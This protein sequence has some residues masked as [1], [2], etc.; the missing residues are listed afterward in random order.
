MNVQELFNLGTEFYAEGRVE[1]AMEIWNRIIRVNP[2]FGPVYLNQHNVYRAQGNLIKARE[3]LIRFTNCPVTMQSIGAR[4]TIFA[5]IAELDK[6]MNP[7]VQ[8]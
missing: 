4:D 1:T 6:Q 3:A 7:Q 8:K 5:Q 2:D